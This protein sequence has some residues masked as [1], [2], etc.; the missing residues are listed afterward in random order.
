MCSC[1][2]S[3]CRE[4]HTSSTICKRLCRITRSG[5]STHLIKFTM[6]AWKIKLK[7]FAYKFHGASSLPCSLAKAEQQ[8]SLFSQV[9]E[10]S[11]GRAQWFICLWLI[12]VGEFYFFP[13]SELFD[14]LFAVLSWEHKLL[15]T[16]GERE[17]TGTFPVRPERMQMLPSSRDRA[18]L[19]IQ[20]FL[21]LSRLHTDL[22]RPSSLRAA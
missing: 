22:P 5:E 17:R 19:R 14:V 21:F 18:S 4:K 16:R 10:L 20:Y 9:L 13:G 7:C 8:K 12:L 1:A 11:W 15:L 6:E 2:P 3:T